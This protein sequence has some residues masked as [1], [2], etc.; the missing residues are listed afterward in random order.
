V[1]ITKKSI[2]IPI[3][4]EIWCSVAV[5]K[6]V[7]IDRMMLD[8]IYTSCSWENNKL[9]SFLKVCMYLNW[10]H[11]NLGFKNIRTIQSL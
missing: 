7:S 10:N 9:R 8:H 2:V 5:H 11:C 6:R 4:S 3:E 1:T